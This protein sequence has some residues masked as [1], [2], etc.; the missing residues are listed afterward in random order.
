MSYRGIDLR[1]LRCAWSWTSGEA[2]RL[3]YGFFIGLKAR[4]M[5]AWDERADLTGQGLQLSGFRT[6]TCSLQF[7]LRRRQRG[8]FVCC[9]R[10]KMG[11][12]PC[13]QSPVGSTIV[14]NEPFCRRKCFLESHD[15]ALGGTPHAA[16]FGLD[17]GKAD[18]SSGRRQHCEP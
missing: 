17:L 7:Q 14:G 12:G 15:H 18:P 4:D 6:K 2:H 10:K 8:E 1:I 5:F 13:R 16:K 3:K 11:N 9:W